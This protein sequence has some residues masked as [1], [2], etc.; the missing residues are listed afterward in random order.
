MPPGWTALLRATHREVRGVNAH[1]TVEDPRLYEGPVWAQ[2]PLLAQ[3]DPMANP[4]CLTA[5][6]WSW[7]EP[8]G[9]G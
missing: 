1:F 8:P 5:Q 2:G 4:G 3:R 6:P 7:A 9:P